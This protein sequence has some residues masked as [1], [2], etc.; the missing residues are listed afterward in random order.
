MRQVRSCIGL[1]SHEERSCACYKANRMCVEM[2]VHFWFCLSSDLDFS[3][4][5]HIYNKPEIWTKENQHFSIFFLF[6]IYIS[7]YFI[8]MNL[9]W[10]RL[11]VFLV[12]IRNSPFQPLF[13]ILESQHK[14]SE[15]QQNKPYHT[16]FCNLIIWRW[17]LWVMFF[18]F[19]FMCSFNL[20]FTSVYR[21]NVNLLFSVCILFIIT[22]DPFQRPHYVYP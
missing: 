8:K 4:M 14:I 21:I 22:S 12:L 16:I 17:T 3:V 5:M 15:D 13:I 7:D 20:G 18:F 11:F 19:F 2:I 9:L 1:I 6:F 10:Y